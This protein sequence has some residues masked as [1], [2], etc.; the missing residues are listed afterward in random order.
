MDGENNK[1]LQEIEL[2]L[3]KIPKNQS[4]LIKDKNNVY[5]KMYKEAKRKAKVAKNLAISSLL[6]AKR[7]KNVYMVED[8]SDTEDSTISE[9]ENLDEDIE[10]E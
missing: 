9:Y 1:D 7:I 5:Y 2:T 3:D 8:S 10:N 4:F 6:E